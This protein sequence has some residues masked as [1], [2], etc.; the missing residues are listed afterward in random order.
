M[1]YWLLIM[2]AI[3]LSLQA[4]GSSC[5]K[6][7]NGD[8]ELEALIAEDLAR[9]A[10]YALPMDMGRFFEG[11][12]SVRG[13]FTVEEIERQSLADIAPRNDIPNVPFSYAL[14][15]WNAFKSKVLFED[16]IYEFQTHTQ[17]GSIAGGYAGHG[18]ALVRDDAVIEVFA[19]TVY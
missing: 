1:K 17:E 8:P 6:N 10:Q 12:V 16:R 14:D 19:N 11:D 2:V 5:I 18:Y 9:R 4:C 13:P 3:I 15:E 7:G